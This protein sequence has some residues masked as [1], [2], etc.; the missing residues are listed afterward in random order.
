MVVVVVVVAAVVVVVAAAAVVVV[1]VVAVVVVVVVVD[2]VVSNSLHP[3]PKK[4]FLELLPQYLESTLLLEILSIREV[5]MF[6][7]SFSHLN[8]A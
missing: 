8:P 6:S 2:V 1:V 4:P 5:G 3:S 7:V